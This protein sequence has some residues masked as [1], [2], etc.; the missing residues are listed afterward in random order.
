MDFV[1]DNFTDEVD[2]ETEK[3]KAWLKKNGVADTVAKAAVDRYAIMT[4][5]IRLATSFFTMKP[6]V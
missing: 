3:F 6:L 4:P 2:D 1:N 5:W